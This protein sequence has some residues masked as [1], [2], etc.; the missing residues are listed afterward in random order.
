MFKISF[1]KKRL[2]LNISLKKP[3]IPGEFRQNSPGNGE[4]KMAG[5]PRGTGNGDPGVKTLLVALRIKQK[6]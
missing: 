6:A 5:D 3:E 1:Y 2:E 4:A